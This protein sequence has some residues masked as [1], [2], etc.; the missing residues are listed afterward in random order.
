MKQRKQKQQ[1]QSIAQQLGNDILSALQYVGYSDADFI[2]HYL[3]PHTRLDLWMMQEV[4]RRDMF[5]LWEATGRI[6]HSVHHS[7]GAYRVWFSDSER[8][9]SCLVIEGGRYL[10]LALKWK[11]SPDEASFLADILDDAIQSAPDFHPSPLI[12]ENVRQRLHTL[13]LK[14]AS[15]STNTP[16]EHSQSLRTKVARI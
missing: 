4:I 3:N 5:F 12:C 2:N 15:P 10:G 13:A 8:L 14:Q 11:L 6:L 7:P 1:Q 9:A 16:Q